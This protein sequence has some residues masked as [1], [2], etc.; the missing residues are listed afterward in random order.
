MLRELILFAALSAV[1][2]SAAAASEPPKEVTNAAVCTNAQAPSSSQTQG[3]VWV[4]QNNTPNG[5][6]WVVQQDKPAK[7]VT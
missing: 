6:V 4:V 1:S 5:P 2:L 3:P 7:P